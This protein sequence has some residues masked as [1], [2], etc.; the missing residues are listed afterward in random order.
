[1]NDF[2]EAVKHTALKDEFISLITHELRTPLTS[3][4]G[5]LGLL[6]SGAIASTPSKVNEIVELAS[7]NVNTLLALINDLL[8]FQKFQSGQLDFEFEPLD[9]DRLAQE[10]CEN[11]EGFAQEHHARI[12]IEAT[13]RA[14]IVGDSVRLAQVLTNL[15]S[16]AI[17]FTP[18]GEEV[19]VRTAL[20]EDKL[21]FSV[22]DKGP[23]IPEDFRG[24]IFSK[25]AQARGENKVKGTGLGLAISKAIVEAHRGSIGFDTKVG[26]GTT[27]HVDLPLRQT[28]L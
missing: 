26:E 13:S 28:V 22:T 8:D 18:A 23:G 17:K 19:V 11:L 24:R 27:F 7:R 12:R 15:I 1:M 3:I 14:T 25:F 10:T 6:E 5:S 9:A 2:A 20:C 4:R 21:R 16:N